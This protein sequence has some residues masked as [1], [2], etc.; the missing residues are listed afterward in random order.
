MLVLASANPILRGRVSNHA[1]RRSLSEIEHVNG[2][3]RTAVKLHVQSHRQRHRRQSSL[4]PQSKEKK[5]DEG[6]D[7]GSGE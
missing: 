3:I 5:S 1:V 6:L 2:G 7:H 4:R